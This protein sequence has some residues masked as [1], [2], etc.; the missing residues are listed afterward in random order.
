MQ[1]EASRPE[2]PLTPAPRT[3]M[4]IVAGILTLISGGSRFLIGL[5]FFVAGFFVSFFPRMDI[6]FDH[7]LLFFSIAAIFFV[8]FAV[9]AIIG[10]IYTLRRK[11]WGWA[12][13][14]AIFAF[15]P[16]NLLGLASI[17]L[18]ALSKREFE[19]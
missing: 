3:A 12:L 2:I 16:F 15:L 9:L 18:V 8:V 17:I 14:G 11:H 7:P 1:P 5:G 10:G 6:R 13:T 4:P 19:S